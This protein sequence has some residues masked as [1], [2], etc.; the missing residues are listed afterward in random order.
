VAAISLIVGNQ[1]DVT[2][3]LFALSF[4]PTVIPLEDRDYKLC[5]A[6]DDVAE[7]PVNGLHGRLNAAGCG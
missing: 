1:F 2:P 6:I 4:G 7:W 3:E 5:I